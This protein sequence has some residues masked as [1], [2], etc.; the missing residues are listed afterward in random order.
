M[1]NK[2][3]KVVPG[4]W[5]IDTD[6]KAIPVVEG[7]NPAMDQVVVD[8]NE[9]KYCARVE[10]CGKD[11]VPTEAQKETASGLI[12]DWILRHKNGF[13]AAT[14]KV[15]VTVGSTPKEK[16]TDVAVPEM[17]I[18]LPKGGL[19][20][21]IVSDADGK[22]NNGFGRIFA[23]PTP[24]GKPADN[25]PAPAETGKPTDNP[26]APPAKAEQPEPAKTEWRYDS[27]KSPRQNILDRLGPVEG[28]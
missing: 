11:Y 5:F 20:P 21:E 2:Q 22:I 17:M 28:F 24:A 25:P 6:G 1:A 15:K 13:P 23:A 27:S 8:I 18:Q 12:N 10:G 14:E 7:M 26:P 19:S 3:K 16:P 4:Y 9:R